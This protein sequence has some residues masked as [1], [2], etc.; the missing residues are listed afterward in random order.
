[1]P[2]KIPAWGLGCLM[3]HGISGSWFYPDTLV[4]RESPVSPVSLWLPS[5]LR[6]H[7]HEKKVSKKV[8]TARRKQDGDLAAEILIQVLIC[9]P[10]QIKSIRFL[11]P[12]VFPV[13]KKGFFLLRGF[14]TS[15]REQTPTTG[16]PEESRG[17]KCPPLGA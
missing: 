11:S 8:T 5:E 4:V 13:R 17:R 1:M 3:S 15:L 7:L 12:G 16:T 9:T 6:L 14:P 10:G 2:P